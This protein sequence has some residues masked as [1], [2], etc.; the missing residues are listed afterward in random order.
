MVAAGV[1][2]FAHYS[3]NEPALPVAGARAGGP[4]LRLDQ[5][6]GGSIRFFG[7]FRDRSTLPCF[8]F[9][10][11]EYV[12]TSIKRAAPLA[13]LVSA[14]ALGGCTYDGAGYGG[15]NV[16][17]GSGYY[18]DDYPY[19]SYDYAPYGWY[20]GYYYP[21]NGYWLY[22]RGGS[23]HRWSDNQRRYWEQRRDHGGKWD[24]PATRPWN[25]QMRNDRRWSNRND[26][27]IG[28]RT[29][30]TRPD[31]AQPRE[32]VLQPRSDGQVSPPNAS[33]RSDGMWS[34]RRW[35]RSGD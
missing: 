4:S 16:G 17:Y 31:T 32:Q 2:G 35:K 20:D 23:R 14:L 8:P 9:L 18:Y 34:G 25:P 28:D 24:G 19:G 15:V 7:K 13:A 30:R 29:W 6:K 26:Q 5:F 12:M 27:P 10:R 3:G 22:D 11:E 33:P 1:V 21:G